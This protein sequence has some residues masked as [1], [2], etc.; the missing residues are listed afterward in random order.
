MDDAA[1]GCL[2]AITFFMAAPFI[3]AAIAWLTGTW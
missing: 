1:A 2:I 3:M